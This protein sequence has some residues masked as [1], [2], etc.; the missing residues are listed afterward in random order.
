MIE[1]FNIDD[2]SAAS[3]ANALQNLDNI[4]TEKILN[5]N[6]IIRLIQKETHDPYK[7]IYKENIRK[8]Y[9]ILKTV[10]QIMNWSILHRNYTVMKVRKIQ[11]K[12]IVLKKPYK[13]LINSL[14]SKTYNFYVILTNSLSEILF[15]KFLIFSLY[16]FL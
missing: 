11:E 10:S 15:L 14:F 13:F 7:K 9:E 6:D 3:L 1:E 12:Y 2:P 4:L 8:I 5:E 16:F